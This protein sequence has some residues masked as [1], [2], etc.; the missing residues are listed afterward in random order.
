MDLSQAFAENSQASTSAA[1]RPLENPQFA[2]SSLK[3][4]MEIG[5]I[6]RDQAIDL[7]KQ[8]GGN[9]DLAIDMLFS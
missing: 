4:L 5:G 3:Q 6:P 7:L 1:A 9:L 8:A 2:E